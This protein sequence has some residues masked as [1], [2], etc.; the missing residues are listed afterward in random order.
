[1]A[2]E[3]GTNLVR[4]IRESIGYSVDDLAVACGLTTDEISQME[5]GTDADPNRLR[6]IASALGLPED[7]VFQGLAERDSRSAA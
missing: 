2:V 5:T 4:A 7:A 3:S 1:M 6:R